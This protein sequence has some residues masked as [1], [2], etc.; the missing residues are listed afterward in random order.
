MATITKTCSNICEIDS[1][2][3]SSTNTGS[4]DCG[5]YGTKLNNCFFNLGTIISSIPSDSRIDSATLTLA[6]VYGGYTATLNMYVKAYSG[7]WDSFSWNSQPTDTGYLQAISLYGRNSGI[8]QFDI[9]TLVQSLLDNSSSS[10]ILKLERN[11]NTASSSTSDA[12]RFS[13]TASNHSLVIT[14]T[15]P[16]ACGAPTTCSLNPTIS[17]STSTLSWGGATAGTLNTITGY[18]IQYAES[19]NGSTWGSWTTLQSVTTTNTYS[20]I[21]VTAPSTRGYYRKYQV[22]T[23]G[24]A[25]SSY[26]SSYFASTNTLKKNEVP[27]TISGTPTVSA[28]NVVS[29]TSVRVSFTNAG[30]NDSNLAG[31]EVAMQDSGDSWYG[32]PTIMGSRTGST[33]TYVD[34]STTGFTSGS[35]WKFLVRGYDTF[36]VRGSWSTATELVTI[37][38]VPSKPRT[39]LYNGG[40]T[41]FFESPVRISWSAPL[42]TYGLS[43]TYEIKLGVWNGTSYDYGSEIS[44]GTTAYYDWVISGE[45]RGQRLYAQVRAVNVI[46]ASEW[47]GNLIDFYYNQ[48]PSTPTIVFPKSSTTIYNASPRIGF[49]Y[50]TDADGQ[51]VTGSVTLDSTTKDS[52]T[53]YWSKQGTQTTA[54]QSLVK[55]WTLAD[56]TY[57]VYAKEN[58]GLVNSSTTQRTFTVETPSLTDSTLTSG[59]TPIK[60][61]HITEL[62]TAIENVYGYYGLTVPTWTDSTITSGVTH[63]KAV[64]V[65]ELRTAIEAIRTYV[66]GF[67][68]GTS[69]DISAFSW[70]DE[71]LSNVRIKAVHIEEIRDAIT[72]L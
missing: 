41:T 69:K 52:T 53:D 50:A 36:G 1:E 70:T 45:S 47:N 38:D 51:A 7:T 9:K 3:P 39:I 34:V 24:S 63:I 65:T 29:G 61:V 12:K 10:N 11:P 68:T 21:S 62:R 37:G 15:A 18:D 60:A 20:S 67:D 58:D 2:L 56:D 43:Y 48:I 40:T 72:I 16:T 8:R 5:D 22:R 33:I 30:D 25:G 64:H 71:S 49:L 42:T 55:G 4:C 14:Y 31:Y 17:E 46:G 23:K 28:T 66:N 44:T 57:T 19:S 26:Y 32:S 27:N 54:M 35:Q 59:I 6:Q 13:T